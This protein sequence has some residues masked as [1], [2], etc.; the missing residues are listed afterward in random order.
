MPIYFSGKP[1]SSLIQYLKASLTNLQKFEIHGTVHFGVLVRASGGESL[2]SRINI[3]TWKFSH[4]VFR[5]W[6]YKKMLLAKGQLISKCLF[7]VFNFFQKM[8]ENTSHSS[9]NKFFRSLFGRIYGL[10]AIKINWPLKSSPKI[11]F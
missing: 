6:S 11:T 9:K 5:N 1:T 8:N 3:L 7:G 10:T 2:W 4:Y